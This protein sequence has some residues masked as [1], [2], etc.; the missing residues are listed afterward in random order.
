LKQLKTLE[1]KIKYHI[2]SY[3]FLLLSISS[4]LLFLFRILIK[5]REEKKKSRKVKEKKLLRLF[6]MVAG[7]YCEQS[8]LKIV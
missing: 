5:R 6:R 1:K 4:P 8:Y 7:G 2:P 3:Y